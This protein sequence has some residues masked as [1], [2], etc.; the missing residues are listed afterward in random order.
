MARIGG[1][2]EWCG[3][4]CSGNVLE[5]MMVILMRA[6]SNEAYG[7]SLTGHCLSPRKAFSAGSGQHSIDFLAKGS[8]MEILKQPWVV[9][10]QE[11]LSAK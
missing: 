3:T 4:Q 10:R 6:A 9:L 2:W 8:P 7:V 11:L 5:S 1:H